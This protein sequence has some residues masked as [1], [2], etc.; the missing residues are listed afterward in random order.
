MNDQTIKLPENFKP[1]TDTFV[2][3]MAY[4]DIQRMRKKFQNDQ[5]FGKE[6]RK[7]LT[8]LERK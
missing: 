2:Q 7:Y 5:E 4:L 1:N 3:V 6:V 8:N